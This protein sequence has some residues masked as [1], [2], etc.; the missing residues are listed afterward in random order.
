RGVFSPA[1]AP[2]KLGTNLRKA[3]LRDDPEAVFREE[4]L[5][6]VLNDLPEG[7]SLVLLFDEFDVLADPEGEQATVA[8]FPYLRGL[9]ASD[10]IRGG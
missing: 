3:V 5:P 1:L 8:F 10:P 6:A 9:L 2:D 7:C 4:W